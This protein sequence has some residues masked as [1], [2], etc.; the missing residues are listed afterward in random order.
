[1]PLGHRALEPFQ[2]ADASVPEDLKR[3]PEVCQMMKNV[4][5]TVDTQLATERVQG[6][7]AQL[8]L[9]TMTKKGIEDQ[10]SKMQCA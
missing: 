2:N 6:N 4:L 3:N 10:L 7:P 9:L 5:A 8:Q 1:M